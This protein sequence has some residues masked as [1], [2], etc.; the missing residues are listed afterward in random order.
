[1]QIEFL[2]LA[3]DFTGALDTGIHFAKNGA[4]TKVI[5]DPMCDFSDADAQVLVIDTETRHL[6]PE[7]A[8]AIVA[9]ITRRACS[10]KIRRFYKKTDSALRGNVG[11]ELAALLE[12][13]AEAVGVGV[14]TGVVGV[15]GVFGV[16]GGV[17]GGVI[18]G[19]GFLGSCLFVIST[20]PP[21]S[22]LLVVVTPL[23]FVTL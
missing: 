12:A 16:V 1:M 2:V 13:D 7:Q 15:V 8:G 3:D 22:V 21:F 5:T 6:P 23:A 11:A 20:L 14:F 17:T 18:G 19:V 10:C 4:R 9:E